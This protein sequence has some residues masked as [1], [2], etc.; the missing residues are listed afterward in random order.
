MNSKKE[1]CQSIHI[2]VHIRVDNQ[3]TGTEDI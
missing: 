2:A 3:Y 1:T